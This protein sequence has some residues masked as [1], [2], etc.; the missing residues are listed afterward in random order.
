MTERAK[1]Y[2]RKRFFIDMFTRDI[3]LIDCTLDLIDNSIDGLI[4]TRTIDLGKDLLEEQQSSSEEK[5]KQLPKIIINFTK[6]QFSITDNCGGITYE[7]AL[8]EVFNF[9][10]P[11]EFKPE[12]AG[13]QLGVYG[14]G[15]K[16]AIFKIGN[17]FEMI[18]RTISD[19]FRVKVEDLTEWVKKDE[20][21]DDWTFPIAKEK[22]ADNEK[23]VGTSLLVKDLRNEILEIIDGD[24]FFNQLQ[25]DIAKTYALFLERYVRIVVNGNTIS[26][27]QIPIGKSN[28]VTPAHKVFKED[29]VD[30]TLIAS[31][32]ARDAKERWTI[33]QAGWYIACN[34]RLVVIADRT[35]LTGWGAGA[36]PSFHSKYRGFVGLALFQSKDPLKLPWKTTKKG[37]N[38]ENIVYQRIRN[39]MRAISRPVLSFLDKMYPSDPKEELYER[40]IADEVTSVDIRTVSRSDLTGFVVPP[41]PHRELKTTVK[42]Q[43]NAKIEHLEKIK[44]HLRRPSMSA[45]Q[46]GQ[47]TLEKYLGT[48]GLL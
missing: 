3:S 6:K 46:I 33:D 38:E 4:R 18:S 24:Q 39:H 41:E 7:E 42:V 5:K 29:G 43:F 16:R 1:A 13:G 2:P 30:V 47:F 28:D 12:D 11:Y 22:K 9:G 14:I 20:S 48:E 40:E 37:L 27:T 15:L 25:R 23:N 34:G 8:N 32:A 36:L 44:K 26:P 35:Y 45:G 17:S 19:G 10:Y 31:L 21:L